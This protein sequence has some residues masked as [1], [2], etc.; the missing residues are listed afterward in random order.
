MRKTLSNV[1]SELNIEN[2]SSVAKDN[3]VKSLE[4]LVIKIGYDPT[5]VKV[6]ECW[7]YDKCVVLD[8][9]PLVAEKLTCTW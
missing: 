9:N 6:V 4:D 8:G 1:Q 5:D 3:R 2:I 7:H